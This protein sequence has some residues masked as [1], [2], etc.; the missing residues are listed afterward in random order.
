MIKFDVIVVGAGIAGAS[1]AAEIGGHCKVLLLEAESMPGFHAT[2]RSAAFWSECYGGSGVQSLT[3][4]SGA[5]LAKPPADFADRPFMTLRGALHIEVPG[6]RDLTGAML[7]DF[8]GSGA[9]IG[10]ADGA[11]IQKL[12]PRVRDEWCTGVWEPDCCDIDVAALHNAYLRRAR[13]HSTTLVCNARVTAATLHSGT[14]AIT[15]TNGQFTGGLL[16]NAAGAWADDLAA[17]SGVTKAGIQPF[18]RSIAQID[19]GPGVDPAMPL[20]MGLDGSFYFKANADGSIWLSPHDE[21][22][23]IA[24]DVV[25]EELDIAAAIHRFEQVTNWQV[26]TVQH[27]WAGLRSFAPDRL[28]VIGR[29]ADRSA[30]FWLAGQGG[31]GI[32][33]APAIAQLAASQILGTDH[34]MPNVDADSFS[35]ARLR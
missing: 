32:Q 5:M 28:P 1:V 7:K 18:R 10:R 33:T 30:F 8:A 19:V 14:W 23:A 16:V 9:N 31:F 2:G 4:A 3:K 34:L 20:V 15:T 11:K 26:S 24:G 6:P 27:K 29:D 25:P 17:I 35:P 12:V 22:P 13:L 21:T